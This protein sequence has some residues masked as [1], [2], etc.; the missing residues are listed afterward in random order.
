M[1]D[2]DDVPFAP[3]WEGSGDALRF[4]GVRNN[5]VG[6]VLVEIDSGNLNVEFS[7]SLSAAL[8]VREQLA[9]AI[10]RAEGR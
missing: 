6:G 7:M 5:G 3:G 2:Q 10:R 4:V 1:N 8:Q 9:E